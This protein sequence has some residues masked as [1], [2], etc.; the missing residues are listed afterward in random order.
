M[1]LAYC[2]QDKP[3]PDPRRTP[4]GILRAG[5]KPQALRKSVVQP[6]PICQGLGGS[7]SSP[8]QD[9]RC[10]PQDEDGSE[11]SHL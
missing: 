9:S 1:A 2:S 7:L 8:F 3:R 4:E 5:S 11:E 6:C 10:P